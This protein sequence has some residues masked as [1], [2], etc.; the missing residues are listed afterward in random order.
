MV[1]FCG[2]NPLP[3]LLHLVSIP[4][5][6]FIFSDYVKSKEKLFYRIEVT[7][8]VLQMDTSIIGKEDQASFKSLSKNFS[9]RITEKEKLSK[10]IDSLKEEHE[11]LFPFSSSFPPDCNNGWQ[12]EFNSSKLENGGNKE[13]MKIRNPF[14]NSP[15]LF[16]G[17]KKGVT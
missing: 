17:D 16:V 14:Q 15:P 1:I 4:E 13:S 2:M 8:L 9:E 12:I 5:K 11:I 3:F 10:M 7:H 6:I